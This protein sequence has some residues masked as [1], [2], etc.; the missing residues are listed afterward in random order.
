MASLA[1]ADAA[2]GEG[3]A[4][5]HK[6]RPD[7]DS[8]SHMESEEE[9]E[10]EEEDDGSDGSIS[11]DGSSNRETPLL[12]GPGHDDDITEASLGVVPLQAPPP[13]LQQQQQMMMMMQGP[14]GQ[15]PQGRGSRLPS[16]AKRAYSESFAEEDDAVE[17][18]DGAA[19][20]LYGASAPV[21]LP[22]AE[23]EAFKRVCRKLNLDAETSEQGID[24]W[25]T[26][27]P[28]LCA[29]DLGK[30]E[31]WVCCALYLAA[32]HGFQGARSASSAHIAFSGITKCCQLT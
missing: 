6:K 27:R 13:P 8:S 9:E 11:S 17:G 30:P 21:E 15:Q 23:M 19:A 4:P 3:D 5:A 28:Y 1:Q 18:G 29:D 24:L 7:G 31:P 10:E 20:R 32:H 25:R 22:P 14:P 16:S 2:V 26:A 12:P